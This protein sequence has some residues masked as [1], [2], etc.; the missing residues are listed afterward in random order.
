MLSFKDLA[1]YIKS[2][3]DGSEETRVDTEILGNYLSNA[4]QLSPRF[5]IYRIIVYI[6][7]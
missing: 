1:K 3:L 2:N 7:L 5:L 6:K 4:I